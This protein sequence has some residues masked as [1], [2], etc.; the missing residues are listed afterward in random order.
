MAN[1]RGKKRTRTL[2]E[3]LWELVSPERDPAKCWPWLGAVVN[4]SGLPRF[5]LMGDSLRPDHLIYER[6]TGPIPKGMKL[7]NTCLMRTC[8]NPYHHSLMPDTWQDRFWEKVHKTD[9]CWHWTGAKSGGYGRFGTGQHTNGTTQAHRI[10]YEL[11]V[12]LIP[13]GMVLDHFLHRKGCVGPACVNP[14][15]LRPCSQ[16][17]N[18]HNSDETW[19]SHNVAKT[20]CPVGH[21][22]GPET[23]KWDRNGNRRCL[24]CKR[25]DNREYMRTRRSSNPRLGSEELP[26]G[27][28]TP[29]VRPTHCPH[30]HEFTEAN[31]YVDKNGANVCRYC[32]SKKGRLE[33]KKNLV[34][35]VPLLYPW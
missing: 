23:T 16:K 14:A 21:E 27:L 2:D 35:E 28:L 31:T 9:T 20:H 24:I 5:T 30:G 15:H 8:C 22:Y 17:V 12:G 26:S 34:T 4:V 13:E 3:R 11:V 10:A 1:L 7:I 33:K 29:G 25:I 19:A 32:N 18:A 6:L